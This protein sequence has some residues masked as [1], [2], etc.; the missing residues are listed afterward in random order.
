MTYAKPWKSYEEQLDLLTSRGLGATDRH[1][2]L[3]YLRRIGYYRLSGYWFPFRER[4]GPLTLFNEKG[5]KPARPNKVETIAL[6]E[7]KPGA[8]FENAVRLYVFDKKLRILAMDAL[9]RIEIALRVDI[10]HTLGK[11]DPFA[12]LRPDLFH[13]SFSRDLNNG[14]GVTRQHEWLSK[15]A[16]LIRDSK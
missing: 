2:A 6:D 3:E 14:K 12:Y 8:T 15:H 13:E 7:F 1:K 16:G 11:L 10:S 4:S 9:E 5:G